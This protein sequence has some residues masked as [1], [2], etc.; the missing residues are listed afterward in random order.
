ML[1]APLTGRGAKAP[2]AKAAAPRR[3][4]GAPALRRDLSED[5]AGGRVIAVG[6]D[7]DEV[8]GYVRSRRFSGLRFR[9]RGGVP[10]SLLGRVAGGAVLLAMLGGF[11]AVLWGARS[12]LL[13][14]PRLVIASSK[15][16]EITGNSHL[17][18]PQLLSVF[19]G[20][21]DRNILT[22]GL[23][24]RRRELETLPWVEH[25]TVMRLLPN[26]VRVAIVERTP[27]AFVRQGSRIGLVDAKGVLLDLSPDG[28][29]NGE[30]ADAHY[31]FPVVT[32]VSEDDPES[33]RAARMALFMRFMSEL[34]AV[35]AK[36]SEVDLSSPE[37]VKALIPSGTNDV[38]VHFGDDDFLKRYTERLKPT[39]RDGRLTYPKLASVDMRYE[40][41]VVLEMAPGVCGAD[42]RQSAVKAAPELAPFV[43]AKTGK[44]MAA[45]KPAPKKAE[46]PKK[47]AAMARPAGMG[48]CSDGVRC[49]DQKKS[50]G[51]MNPKPEN[52]ITVLDAGSQKSVRGGG[53]GRRWRA[54]LSR[55][56]RSSNRSACARG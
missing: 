22:V 43:S 17:T 50:G 38:L 30:Q 54:A 44:Q 25:A 28:S 12:L 1:D 8:P 16:I 40:H 48:I 6:D 41:N 36:L 14:D 49:A 19:G 46:K 29:A 39:F 15:S 18:R 32:G 2:G 7:E 23:A 27:V 21:V 24:E 56:R 51:P 47:A 34:G 45:K 10:K 35:S 5:F 55:A 4:P 26:K 37:D 11:T 31:S 53:G 52:L 3:V 9:L 42:R 13:H 33:T 20:D